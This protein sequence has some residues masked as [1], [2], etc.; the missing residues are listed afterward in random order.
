MLACI[1]YEECFRLSLYALRRRMT[2]YCSCKVD[3][4]VQRNSC[5]SYTFVT[6]EVL[7]DRCDT[8]GTYGWVVLPNQEPGNEMRALKSMNE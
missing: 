4:M 3:Y 7:N 2:V 1:N 5:I 8:C 6:S